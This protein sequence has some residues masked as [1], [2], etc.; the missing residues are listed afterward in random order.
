MVSHQPETSNETW[1]SCKEEIRKIIK[2]K[3]DITDDMEIDHC[4]H[5]CKGS[6]ECG[7]NKKYRNLRL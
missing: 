5:M 4:H 1:E 3:L 7:K 6:A 2:N